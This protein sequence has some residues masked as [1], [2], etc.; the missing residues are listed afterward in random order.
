VAT[1]IAG[2]T[3]SE[4]VRYCWAFIAA[5]VAVLLLVVF[6]PELASWI[7]HMVLG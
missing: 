3:Y 6:V 5:E 1:S 7:P 2:C 4:T